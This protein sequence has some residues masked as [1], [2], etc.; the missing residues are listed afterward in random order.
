ME[1]KKQRIET[2]CQRT[3]ERTNRS[4][5]ITSRPVICSNEMELPTRTRL[6][7][8]SFRVYIDRTMNFIDHLSTVLEIGTSTAALCVHTNAQVKAASTAHPA[9]I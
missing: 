4:V 3:K 9:T 7:G 6:I 5:F 8:R 2:A 1:W